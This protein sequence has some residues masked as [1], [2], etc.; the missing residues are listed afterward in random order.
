MPGVCEGQIIFFSFPFFLF[1]LWQL[2]MVQPFASILASV[3]LLFLWE[4]LL[5]LGPLDDVIEISTLRLS[6]EARAKVQTSL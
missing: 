4:Q 3:L 2:L 6:A 5:A 1:F